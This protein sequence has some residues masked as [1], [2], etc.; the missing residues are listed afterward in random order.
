MASY[1]GHLCVV[2]FLVNSKANINDLA[3]G[4]PSG[5]PLHFA[6]FNGQKCVVDCL[7]NHGA[8]IETTNEYF[9]TPLHL[10]ASNGQISVVKLL[11]NQNVNINAKEKNSEMCCIRTPLFILQFK[12]V[13]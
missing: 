1:N 10:A 2:D 13:I 4:C 7:T 9:E 12:N 3:N 5:T 8:N 11:V 6:A